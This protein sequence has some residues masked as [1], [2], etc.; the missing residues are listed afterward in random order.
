[1]THNSRS[2]HWNW[3]VLTVSFLERTTSVTPLTPD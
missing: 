1:M 2:P 3:A